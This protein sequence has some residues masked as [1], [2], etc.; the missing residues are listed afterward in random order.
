MSGLSKYSAEELRAELDRRTR[1]AKNAQGL[2]RCKDCTKPG[3][4]KFA[5]RLH[6]GVWR[7]CEHYNSKD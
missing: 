3:V 5:S 4:C 1:K 6:E 7:Y 2:V